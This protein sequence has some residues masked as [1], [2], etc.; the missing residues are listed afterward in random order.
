[1]FHADL[2]IHSRFS[3][4][5]SRDCD[6][7]HL[8][9]WALRK[10]ITVVGTGDFTHPGWAEELRENLVPAE[11]GLFRLGEDAEARLRRTSPRSCAGEVRFMLSAE[12]STIYRGG[13]RTRKV[14]HLLYAP[15]F[16][17]AERIT[18][19]LSRIGNLASDGRPILGLDS[20]HLLE[21]TLDGGP[22]C[23]LVPA[24]AWTPWFAVLGSKSGFDVVADCYRDLAGHVF[25][26]ETGLSSDPAMNWMC[27]SLDGFR[28][29]SNSDA[30]SPPMLGREATTF[31]VPLDYFAMADALRTGE[32]LAGT[33]EFYPE[34]GKYHLDG[35]RKCGVRFEPAQSIQNGG[36]CP[37]CGKPLT[38]GVLHRVAELADRPAGYRPPGAPGFTNLVQLPQIVGEI[39]A[40]G[41]KSKKVSAEVARLVATLGPEL[42][43][44][45]EVAA[46]DLRR[47]GGSVLAEA[48]GR[49]RRGE[50]RREA[51]Y[52]GEYGVIALFGPGELDRADA[53]FDLG[54]PAAARGPSRAPGSAGRAGRAGKKTAPAPRPPAA[55]HG[56]QGGTA[57]ENADGLLLPP[58]AGELVLA[59]LDPDQR[60]AAAADSPLMIIAGPGTGKTRTLTYRIAHDVLGRDV[61]PQAC[62]AITFTRRAAEEMRGRLTALLPGRAPAITVTTFHGLGLTI[63]REHHAR[64][65]LAAGFRVADDA[66]R[67]EVAAELMGS[68]REARRLLAE[69][70]GDQTARELLVKALAARDLVDFDGLIE[71]PAALLAAEP[72]VAASLRERWPRI[73]V[74]E[75]QDIDAAQ[76]RLLRLLAGEGR[77]LTVIGD[78]DQAIYGFRGADV[79]L[80]LRFAEDFPGATTRQLTRN[81]R[82][83]GAIVTGALQAIRPSSL[84]PGR[85]L[86]PA[87]G[88]PGAPETHAGHGTLPVP[89]DYPIGFHE[90]ADERAEGAWIA[91]EI[92]RLLGGASFHA[93]DT[94][95]SGAHGHEGLG[96]SDVAVLYRTDAQAEPLGQAL[97]RAGLP[98]Q[99]S[100]HDL[101]E[102]RTGVPGIVREMRL[103]FAGETGR[104]D[105]A[106]GTAVAE[107][108]RRAVRKLA[109]RMTEAGDAG[110]ALDARTAGEVLAPLARRCGGDLDRFLTEIS[111]GAET[112]AL[113]P[114]ADAVTLLTLHAAK[115]LEFEVVF[116]AGCEKALLPLWLPGQPPLAA[117]ELAEERR[118]LFVG[119][120]RARARL[121]LTCASRRTRQGSARE[122]GVSPFLAAID[123]ALLDRSA[124]PARP[125]RPAS[126]QLRLL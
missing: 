41:P 69:T 16:Q 25:A 13:E 77:G 75:Y 56:G 71:L 99:K 96:L 102:R 52:D 29:V 112:D 45:T 55:G 80:F 104:S 33:I 68:P 10:G 57:A 67:L 108:L 21:I 90:A 62:L 76:Y 88:A 1:M 94:G 113:D 30:H 74:D 115:G 22:G 73:S 125:V 35:H 38:I 91:R 84:V 54:E 66:A 86:R 43:I 92:E 72:A 59:G 20:R 110:A 5:C 118:L 89:A 6:L 61:A 11:P 3:R 24:H 123:P 82:S 42:G 15:T 51:G 31:G 78:P 117:A 120:T 39:L 26:I 9:W 60:A 44:L 122:A 4:A 36:T 49:L 83:G 37:E 93:L 28:L 53:L 116:L 79:T 95:R 111:L 103:A 98:F 126:R 109:A 63:L 106:D 8:A 81:Y 65:G 97:T 70:A 7:E 18:D 12:I 40:T 121:F 2:H 100:S 87:G 23:Y 48:V 58:G 27:S 34:E 107:R 47:A 85:V 32:G 101:L 114:R 14:H 17:A 124:G 64:A 105:A 119:M 46:E 50:V 19:A